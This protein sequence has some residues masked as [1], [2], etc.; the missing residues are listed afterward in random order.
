MWIKILKFFHRFFLDK[1]EKEFLKISKIKNKKNFYKKN[2]AVQ[3]TINNYYYI[4][5]L[6][7]I[8]SKK[9]FKEYNFIGI[10][11]YDI[12]VNQI[13][14]KIL[15]KIYDFK[16]E[17][18]FFLEKRKWSKFYTNLGIKKIYD[19][20]HLFYKY[21]KNRK[22]FSKK[23]ILNF[24][25]RGI[26][27]GDLIY[28]T[29]IRFRNKPTVDLNDSSINEYLES[30]NYNYSQLINIYNKFKFDYYFS[31]YASYIQHGFPVRFF[32]Q[33]KVSVFSSGCNHYN[34][35][36]IK[37][38]DFLHNIDFKR[39]KKLF[40]N[41]KN[42]KKNLL[43]SKVDL[44]KKFL[45]MNSLSSNYL[46][47]NPFSL[48]S[49]KKIKK[50]KGVL[51]LHDFLDAPH[52]RGGHM[53]FNDYYEW[54]LHSIEFIKKN[55]LDIAIKPHP[56]SINDSKKIEI[57]IKNKFKNLLWL[58]TRVNNL[59]IYKNTDFVVSVNG[60]VLY[61]AA[62]FNKIGI[63]AGLNPT[64]SFKLFK[65]PKTI[66]EYENFLINP[67]KAK[68]KNKNIKNDV[69][70]L[71]YAYYY[72]QKDYLPKLKSNINLLEMKRDNS[73]DFLK[74]SKLINDNERD[75]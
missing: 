55:N 29:L 46:R 21:E 14:N 67:Q 51:F 75:N 36:K 69:L 64:S 11:S 3:C 74:Y 23:D 45:G 43:T 47:N 61:E 17:I 65:E 58:S 25:Y 41:Q 53:L 13:E 32:L 49:G 48:E 27:V 33:K 8:L 4:L 2:L 59:D 5:L 7:S 37:K 72:G 20:G 22:F 62:Y 50:V 54:A 6:K 31:N 15:K 68:F 52:D 57:E 39:L 30:I 35:K 44:Q 63:S 60:S 40:N 34:L 24:K 73:E 42:K 26:L 56:N 38:N 70:K 66:E 12:K 28:D 10:W 18:V 71:Y 1:Y 16:N 9:K 19:L